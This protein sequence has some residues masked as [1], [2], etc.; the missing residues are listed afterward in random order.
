MTLQEAPSNLLKSKTTK[1]IFQPPKYDPVYNPFLHIIYVICYI[2]C[3]IYV[4]YILCIKRQVQLWRR[5]PLAG[6]FL[7]ISF[8]LCLGI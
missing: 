7:L 2:M 4:L 1:Y 6:F 5:I 8:W 3:I